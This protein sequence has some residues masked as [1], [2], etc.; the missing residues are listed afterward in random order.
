MQPEFFSQPTNQ[1]ELIS[2]SFWTLLRIRLLHSADC[3][4]ATFSLSFIS[5]NWIYREWDALFAFHTYEN[6]KM[7]KMLAPAL[8]FFNFSVYTFPSMM[9]A[10][11]HKSLFCKSKWAFNRHIQ[12]TYTCAMRR[13]WRRDSNYIVYN[14]EA[15][16]IRFSPLFRWGRLR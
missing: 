12:R 8:G 9:T 1:S 16:T 13:R 14:R 6:V 3:F 4:R 15:T 11:S 7:L 10:L 5:L 2:G